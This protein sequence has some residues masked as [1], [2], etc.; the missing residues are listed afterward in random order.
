MVA[1]GKRVINA[2]GR[3]RVEPGH[4]EFFLVLVIDDICVKRFHLNHDDVRVDGIRNGRG[5]CGPVV[6]LTDMRT[7]VG[8]VQEIHD[9]KGQEAVFRYHGDIAGIGIVHS[10]QRKFQRRLPFV[11]KPEEDD[12]P[13]IHDRLE[14][15]PSIHIGEAAIK[16][17]N[18]YQ[19]RQVDKYE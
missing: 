2:L 6:E 7:C 3:Q 8:V 4:H 14:K 16:N 5:D 13:G 17:K 19:K 9:V 10:L 11:K 15:I 1:H 12:A 18:H